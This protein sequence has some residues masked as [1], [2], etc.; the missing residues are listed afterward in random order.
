MF[1]LCSKRISKQNCWNRAAAKWGN[2]RDYLVVSCIYLSYQSLNIYLR[3]FPVTRK[4]DP[5]SSTRLKV[6]Q[7][8]ARQWPP[9]SPWE[10][11]PCPVLPGPGPGVK[12]VIVLQHPH[13]P[14]DLSTQVS[15]VADPLDLHEGIPSDARV[16]VAVLVL[17]NLNLRKRRI[18]Y[19]VGLGPVHF[20]L[21]VNIRGLWN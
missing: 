18:E 15:G 2:P 9:G 16:A 4:W 12:P 11:P 5:F 19:F 6:H 3:I 10:T 20:I 7:P 1:Q 14:G 21:K 17:R 13:L 8:Y